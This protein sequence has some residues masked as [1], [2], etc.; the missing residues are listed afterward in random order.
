MMLE[1]QYKTFLNLTINHLKIALISPY[2]F[3]LPGGVQ[4]HIFHLAKELKKQ[5][6]IVTIFAPLSNKNIHSVEDVKF[7]SLGSGKK[8]AALGSKATISL[9]FIKIFS[10]RNFF[11]TDTFDIIHLHEPMIASNLFINIISSNVPKIATFHAYSKHLNYFYFFFNY[12]LNFFI[13]R[14]NTLICV[15]ELSK[16]YISKY[17]H[18]N[19]F[20]IPNGINFK[21]FSIK[22]NIP[23]EIQSKENKILFV[24]RFDEKRKGLDLLY[25]AFC[26][27]RKK[28]SNIKLI[29]IGPGDINYLRKFSDYYEYESDIQ[30]LGIID[31]NEISSYYQNVDIFCSPAISNESFGIVLIEAMASKTIVVASN[32]S[33]YQKVLDDGKLGFLFKSGSINSLE[34]VL[35]QIL[36]K[37]IPTNKKIIKALNNTKKY[38]W[39]FIVS[40]I[41]NKYTNTIINSNN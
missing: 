22:N 37:K 23:K 25:L 13:K 35:F 16:D 27:L 29:I 4:S 7:F 15:S 11:N 34:E 10:Y 1:G 18:N 9:D 17:F 2:D 39:E 36:E 32:I 8:F 26:K 21:A 41:I 38:S 3:S 6:N 5:D 40:E 28:I 20:I 33:G 24:G 30:Y 14:I 19:Y 31:Q 12:I